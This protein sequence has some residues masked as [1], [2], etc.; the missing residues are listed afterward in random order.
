[1][2]NGDNRMALRRDEY[3]EG[4]AKRKVHD[5]VIIEQ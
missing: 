4:Q 3:G 5:R 1:L 2:A